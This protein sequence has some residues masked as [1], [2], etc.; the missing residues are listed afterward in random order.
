MARRKG[1][2]R[3]CTVKKKEEYT[4]STLGCTRVRVKMALKGENIIKKKKDKQQKT[5]KKKDK[6]IQNEFKF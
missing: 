6:L 5:K 3:F 2:I 1:E 4:D